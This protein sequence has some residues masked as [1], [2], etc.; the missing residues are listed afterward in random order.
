MARA[1]RRPGKACQTRAEVAASLGFHVDSAAHART[2]ILRAC[3][4]FVLAGR[5]QRTLRGTSTRRC[6]ARTRLSRLVASAGIPC[7]ALVTRHLTGELCERKVARDALALVHVNSARSR[8]RRVRGT[9]DTVCVV[10]LVL[11]RS[12]RAKCAARG[13]GM[14]RAI[15]CVDMPSRFKR[16]SAPKDTR[17]TRDCQGYLQEACR[18]NKGL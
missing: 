8:C 5:A 11:V 7:R 15:N 9:G 12:R 17:V 10:G 3:C 2:R 6:A 13:R 4:V 1:T 14:I 18:R 16:W